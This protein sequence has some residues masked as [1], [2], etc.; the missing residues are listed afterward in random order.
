MRRS[1]EKGEEKGWDTVRLHTGDP[2]LYGA[3]REQ[4]DALRER[5]IPFDVTPGVSSRLPQEFRPPKG[6]EIR[7]PGACSHKMYHFSPPPG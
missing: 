2:S 6:D 7:G 5:H 1:M 3:V 4:M